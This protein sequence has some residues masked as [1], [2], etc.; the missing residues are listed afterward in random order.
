MDTITYASPLGPLTLLADQAALV[1]CWFDSQAYFGGAFDLAQAHHRET[2][3][4]Q[5]ASAWL[6]A[7]FAGRQPTQKVPL[8]LTGTPFRQAVAA[9]LQQIPWGHTV[10]YQALAARLA[11]TGRVTSPRAIGGAVGHNPLSL[12]VPCHRVV[13]VSGALTGYAGG[14]RRK[15]ALLELEGVP[16]DRVHDRIDK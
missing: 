12:F 11:H 9:Q 14:L 8:R 10:T 1:G 7:Y 15:V 2:P 5:A 16:V 3:V 13:A 4:L 6:D